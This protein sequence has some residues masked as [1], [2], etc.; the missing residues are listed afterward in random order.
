MSRGN[1][2]GVRSSALI[3]EL[4][5]RLFFVSGALG[6]PSLGSFGFDIRVTLSLVVQ[7]IPFLLPS[8]C[9]AKVPLLSAEALSSVLS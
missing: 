3:S 4:S 1:R 7:T 6:G 8:L 5:I 9:G 2:I